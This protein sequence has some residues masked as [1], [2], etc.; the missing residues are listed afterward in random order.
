M[1]PLSVE[2]LIKVDDREDGD[3][4]VSDVFSA[5]DVGNNDVLDFRR[6]LDVDLVKVR[7]GDL[8]IV[9]KMLDDDV[10]VTVLDDDDDVL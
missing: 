8:T 9:D 5:I 2:A 7:P 3:V 1:P 10:K 6:L 4:V